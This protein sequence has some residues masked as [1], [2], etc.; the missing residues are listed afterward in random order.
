MVNNSKVM[1]GCKD[2]GCL[3]CCGYEKGNTLF[4]II[5]Y[6]LLPLIDPQVMSPFD[7]LDRTA[8]DV[9]S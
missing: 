5:E 4:Y 6:H 2:R 3:S 1:E 7:N 8:I 9:D